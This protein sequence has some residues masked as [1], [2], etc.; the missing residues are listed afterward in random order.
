MNKTLSKLGGQWHWRMTMGGLAKTTLAI[1]LSVCSLQIQAQSL[2]VTGKVID[3]TGSAI[4]GVNVIVKGTTNGTTTD[5]DGQ[6]KISLGD[7]N[8]TLAFSFIGFVTQEIQ[9]GNKTV[10]D[11]KLTS[12]IKS[13]EE[14][15]VVGY[16]TQNKKDI[17]IAATEVDSKSLNTTIQSSLAGALQGRVAGV[18]VTSNSGAPGSASTVRIRG[19]GSWNNSQPLYVVD[20]VILGGD[21]PDYLSSSDIESTTVL[22]DAAATAIYGAR[23]ANGV[24]LITTKGGKFNQKATANF[25]SSYGVQSIARKIS[26]LNAEQYAVISNEGY[27]NKGVTS[28][29]P[30]LANPKALGKG[31]DWQDAIFQAA[32]M[33]QHQLSFSGGSS[34]TNYYISGTH[35]NQNGIVGGDKSNFTRSTIVANINTEIGEKLKISANITLAHKLKNNLSE[36]NIFGNPIIRAINMDPITPVR[37][38]DGSFAAS[39]YQETDI[40]NPLNSSIALNNNTYGEDRFV[41]GIN[42]AYKII[43]GLTLEPRL[44]INVGYGEGRSLTPSYKAYT[45]NGVQPTNEVVNQNGVNNFIQKDFYY[46]SENQLRYKRSFATVHNFEVVGGFAVSESIFT[47]LGASQVDLPTNDFDKAYI[48]ASKNAI[49]LPSYGGIGIVK[50]SSIYGRLNYDYDKR[51]FLTASARQDGSSKFGENKKYGF[52]PAFSAAWVVSKESFFH[53]PAISFLKIR[54]G[55][56]KNGNDRS[57]GAYGFT[58]TINNGYN[59]NFNGVKAN[60]SAPTTPGNTDIHWEQIVQSNI[61]FNLGLFDDRLSFEVDLYNKVSEDVIAPQPLS[62]LVGALVNPLFN[63]GQVSNKGIE[64]KATYKKNFGDLG[65][66]LEANGGY[67]KNEVL[68]INTVGGTYQTSNTQTYG[69]FIGQTQSG[70]TV[71]AF[72]GYVT[73]G[74]FQTV[75]EV[76]AYTGKDGKLLQSDAVP[77]DIRFVDVN[78]DGVLDEKDKAVVGSPIPKVTFGINTALTYKGFDLTLFLQGATGMQVAQAFIKSD[79]AGANRLSSALERW[80]GPGTSNSEPRFTFDDK[81]RNS[82]FSD[83][84][85]KDADYMR[86]KTLQVGYTLPASIIQ[87]I[88]IQNLRV[89]VSAQNL[90]TFTLYNGFDPEIG[91]TTQYQDQPLNMGVD[92]GYFPLPRIITGGIQ[93]KF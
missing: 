25:E 78:R 62:A 33:Q 73:N 38:P 47:N 89:Y 59:Y 34:S 86:I 75:A 51:Y 14:V 23:G 46:Q 20:N 7:A 76:N 50:F 67:N 26:L 32:P 45:T 85:V 31:T 80:T 41:G 77:G 13:L 54:G 48:S 12:D 87:K 36:N 35:F 63:I 40:K 15:I 39:K 60:G 17:S 56:G 57:A 8:S 5:V 18:T 29:Y 69:D 52:F 9:V 6:Y 65:L 3:E 42:F 91:S 28:P 79:F 30:E 90:Y 74:L 19:V 24:I 68:R 88:K 1:L 11:V 49:P 44:G 64:I 10:I 16:G 22:K 92:T 83:R 81:N 37:L 66:V 71:G 4:P 82:R 72:Y 2:T 43:E 27:L 84:F 58:T 21:A 55:W 53:V 61:G 70:T 93:I